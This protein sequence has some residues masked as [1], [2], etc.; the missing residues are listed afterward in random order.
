M[1]TLKRDGIKASR[2]APTLIILFLSKSTTMSTP[3]E[4]IRK[5]MQ[6]PLLTPQQ[7][8]AKDTVDAAGAWV[9][10]VADKKPEEDSTMDEKAKWAEEWNAAVGEWMSIVETAASTGWKVC[11]SPHV[12][13]RLDSYSEASDRF[14]RE[15]DEERQRE[16]EERRPREAEE[17]RRR[18]EQQAEIRREEENERRRHHEEDQRRREE[19]EKNQQTEQTGQDK[20]TDRSCKV[21]DLTANTDGEQRGK[22]AVTPQPALASLKIKVPGGKHYRAITPLFLPDD[23]EVEEITIKTAK[24]GPSGKIIKHDKPSN[25]HVKRKRSCRS[26]I[27]RAKSDKGKGK[28]T[29]VEPPEQMSNNATGHAG[30]SRNVVRADVVRVVFQDEIRPKK[31]VKTDESIPM[32]PAKIALL[33]LEAA[34][35]LKQSQLLQ[36]GAEVATMYTDLELIK[37]S[38]DMEQR[39]DGHREM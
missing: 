12:T 25:M 10:V 36:M 18:E 16:E 2:D 32:D 33:R 24:N 26:S 15:R 22:E 39:M 27:G 31:R 11:V 19:E 1:R 7:E 35:R 3:L 28:A 34:L 9:L 21:N 38:L 13:E 20:L 17:A 4:R 8:E 6:L 30:P 5:L 29:P 14:I 37:C 23:D